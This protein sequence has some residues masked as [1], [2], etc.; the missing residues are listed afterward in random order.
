MSDRALGV[1]LD[2]SPSTR[3]VLSRRGAGDKR[4]GHQFSR[5]P[6]CRVRLAV[7]PRRVGVQ[8]AGPPRN[9]RS[10]SGVERSGPRTSAE[11]HPGV[12][13]ADRGGDQLAWRH[14]TSRKM[15]PA[16]RK[17]PAS[18]YL[19]GPGPLYPDPVV[20]PG[21]S[22]ACRGGC[23]RG[24]LRHGHPARRSRTSR[25]G[26]Q[27]SRPRRTTAYAAAPRGSAAAAPHAGVV[28]RGQGQQAD[29]VAGEDQVLDQ[30]EAV[31]AVHDARREPA[32]EASVRTASSSAVLRELTI[33]SWSAYSARSV[34]FR[35]RRPVA[36]TPRPHGTLPQRPQRPPSS[37]DR[38]AGAR[39]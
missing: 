21:R 35:V 27:A 11:D 26:G 17:G 5:P 18:P 31:D 13:R 7:R 23:R 16:N 6:A 29:P 33:Q 9:P 25:S 3:R 2:R 24:V 32:S 36:G 15:G 19:A 14:R 1:F 38:H 10:A 22:A 12:M 28:G 34:G 4:V 20:K 8:T 39:L 30:L 37:L